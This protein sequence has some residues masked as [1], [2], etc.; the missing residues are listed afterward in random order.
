MAKTSEQQAPDR[1]GG[2]VDGSSEVQVDL[3][4]GE[5]VGDGPG[6]GEGAGE[7]VELGDH[8][9]VAGP[10]GSECLSQSRPLPVGAGEAVVD[11]DPL[12]GHAGGGEAIPLGGE[13]L[14]VGGVGG[15]SGVP[16][17]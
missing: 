14:G 13:V 2:V 11:I 10:A 9:G 8:Q 1:V 17:E 12:R 7:T 16:D 15:A 4:G 5:L 3:T 6:V